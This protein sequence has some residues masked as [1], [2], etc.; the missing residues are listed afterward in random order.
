MTAAPDKDLPFVARC[1]PGENPVVDPLKPG[2][3]CPICQEGRMD[4]DG[5]LNLACN[6]CGYTL[7]EAA[8]CT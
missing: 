8:G 2:D 3:F 4:Y 7:S 1:K 6:E 5:L